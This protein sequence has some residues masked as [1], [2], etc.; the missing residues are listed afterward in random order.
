MAKRTPVAAPHRLHHVNV[1]VQDLQ[2]PYYV[3]GSLGGKLTRVREA[4]WF[5]PDSQEFVFANGK[6][7]FDAIP[8]PHPPMQKSGRAKERES[9]QLRLAESQQ[10]LNAANTALRKADTPKEKSQARAAVHKAEEI[11][12]V[13]AKA[14]EGVK[15]ST[16]KIDEQARTVIEPPKFGASTLQRGGLPILSE[17]DKKNDQ[18]RLFFMGARERDGHDDCDSRFAQCDNI[19][20]VVKDR[21]A[22]FTDP[23][24]GNRGECGY[25]AVSSWDYPDAVKALAKIPGVRIMG[26]PELDLSKKFK[27]LDA[28][29]KAVDT[30]KIFY[31]DERPPRIGQYKDGTPAPFQMDGIRFLMSRDHAILADDM[32]LGKTYQAIV[33]AHNSV[34]KDQQILVLCP[35]AVIG[36]WLA[37]IAAFMPSAAA[38]GFDTKYITREGAPPVRPEKVRF[39][40]CSYQGASSQEG[41]AAVSKLLLGRQWGLIIL[42]EAHRLK[43]P[44]TLGHKF[45]E[46]LKTDR[47][48]FLTGTPISNR[49]IDY[50]GLLKLAHHPAGRRLDE[51]IEKYV[52]GTVRAGKT[53]VAMDQGPLLALG[54]GLSGLVLRRTKEEVLS[55][56]LPK[57]FGGLAAA[58]EG[59]LRAEL[60]AQFSKM[61]AAAHEEGV[62]RERLRH[63]LA[64]AKVPGT[65]EVAQRVIDAGDK[66]VLF[67][68]Y[69]DVLHSF[70]ELCL[71]AKVLFIV[72]SG[73]IQTIG[74]SA[75]VKL[76]QGDPLSVEKDNNEEKWAQ[77]NLGQW[78]LNLVRYV[79]TSEWKKPDLEEARRRF[80]HNEADWPHEIQVVLAQ[81]VAAS[82][83]V[84]LTKADTLVFNDLDY[85]PSRH[86][87]AEDRIYRLSKS[88]RLPH[89]EVYIG[90]MYSNDPVNIDQSILINLKAKQDEINTV[91]DATSQDTEAAAKKVRGKFLHELKQAREAQLQS[92]RKL[93]APA[94]RR[95]R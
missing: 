71:D 39:F 48:W 50:Y 18:V 73:E 92:S 33:A 5:D 38:I 60:P 58:P 52:P 81:M 75:M 17:Y 51:F 69:T 70:A 54:E 64:V 91:Y 11:K 23:N 9:L 41:K 3:E 74:K 29:A 36:S 14:L 87:Q 77:K 30:K 19:V 59:F 25:W 67:S 34:P 78:W 12:A 84:T 88:G 24:A 94:Q 8:T 76:F 37:D 32:G 44:G 1:D 79:P 2:G 56:D 93:A 47:M 21:L 90:Y 45:V 62:P 80:G 7:A 46:K 10:I 89:P 83:G 63:A 15:T 28:K 6:L 72:I 31:M 61:L 86:A 49:V 22:A 35:A 68:T 40:I 26:A 53:E 20:P 65:W 66:I 95:R 82:E 85:M 57:K 4:V 16:Q 13:V 42:D 27:A 55:K 43:K